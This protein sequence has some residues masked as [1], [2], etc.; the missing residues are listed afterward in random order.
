MVRQRPVGVAS[1]DRLECNDDSWRG[2]R[3][4]RVP[5]AAPVARHWVRC[6]W[7][8]SPSRARHSRYLERL[9]AAG[10]GLLATLPF[11]A[12][13]AML[14]VLLVEAMPSI[15]YNGTRF[16]T[17]STWTIGNT[18]GDILHSGGVA[19]LAGAEFGSWPLIVGTLESSAIALLVGLPIA[20]GAA[21]L[22]VE[23]LPA[24]A[25]TVIGICLEIL[26]GI[27]SIVIGVWGALTFGPWIA[28]EIYPRSRTCRTC[29]RSTSSGAPSAT[30]R[31]C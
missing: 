25:G 7:Q 14:V 8:R 1:R 5:P 6:S 3:A 18:Y 17:S 29:R 28:K 11:A 10:S 13:I 19:H 12:L 23:K 30:A 9:L 27:P 26:A 21:V 15:R 16:V 31:G 22:V 4:R 2:G 24:R 20:V